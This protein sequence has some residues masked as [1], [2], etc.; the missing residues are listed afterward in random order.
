MHSYLRRGL[1]PRPLSGE[2]TRHAR[3]GEDHVELLGLIR[4]LSESRGL[5]L[6]AVQR[7]FEAA[8]FDPA[9]VRRALQGGRLP[10]PG[11]AAEAEIFLTLEEVARRAALPLDGPSGLRALLEAGA[12]LS[13]EDAPPEHLPEPAVETARA[14]SELLAEGFELAEAREV[15]RLAHALSAIERRPLFRA[16]AAAHGAAIAGARERRG[17]GLRRRHAALSRLI[18]ALRRQE[19]GH[20]LRQLEELRQRAADFARAA[21]YVPSRLFLERFGLEACAAA[22]MERARRPGA[23]GEVRVALGRLLLGLGRYEDVEPWLKGLPQGD[24]HEAEAWAYLGVARALGGRIG[25]ARRA[26]QRALDRSPESP[27]AHA[28]L[29]V[30]LALD[31]ATTRG[32]FNPADILP[33]AI[34]AVRRSYALEPADPAEEM[35]T[36]LARGRLLSVLP[37]ELQ[38]HAQGLADLEQ[39]LAAT[40]PEACAHAAFALPGTREV[41][42]E[43]ALF[44]L[45]VLAHREGDLPRA[46]ALLG[47]CIALDPGSN[48]AEAA[49]RLLAS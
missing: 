12:L 40:L 22:L 8:A 9:R 32:P 19:L 47:E 25:A 43:N 34:A 24:P 17:D 35:E 2:G 48:F 3:Y 31:A 29:G 39:V 45:G 23:P 27:R 33:E 49:Y 5:S 28:F 6:E 37:P 38:E 46:R 26:I 1:L 21:V 42:R 15:A 41:Y 4:E 30:V 13:D 11:E 10:P 7:T 18:A 44:Y 16:T 20:T 14:L 36:R